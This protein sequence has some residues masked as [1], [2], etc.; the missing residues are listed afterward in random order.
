MG[1]APDTN[2]YG[3]IVVTKNNDRGYNSAARLGA[4]VTGAYAGNGSARH[5]MRGRLRR[6][7][8]RRKEVRFVT[9]VMENSLLHLLHQRHSM[10]DC[11]NISLEQLG[12]RF[13]AEV[14]Q[15]LQK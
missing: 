10:V 5:Q 1:E 9:V 12:Q 13:S 11:M 8:Q 15:G 7:G 6:M 4:L 14:V 3:I 2:E